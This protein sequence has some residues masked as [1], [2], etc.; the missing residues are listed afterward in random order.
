MFTKQELTVLQTSLR[1]WEGPFPHNEDCHYAEGYNFKKGEFCRCF[2]K[3]S[4]G[5]KTTREQ[6]LVCR[7]A[8]KDGLKTAHELAWRFESILQHY[9]EMEN[10]HLP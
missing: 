8:Q 6:R 3:L 5:G 4:D 10:S 1:A 2:D 9:H 7:T